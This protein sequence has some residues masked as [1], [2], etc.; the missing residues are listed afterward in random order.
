MVNRLTWTVHISIHMNGHPYRKNYM[1]FVN[2][3]F[4]L[5]FSEF[6]LVSMMKMCSFRL[7]L[8]F[9]KHTGSETVGINESKRH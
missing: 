4:V 1:I 3:L 8:G 7:Q 2:T 9:R 6:L 5:L